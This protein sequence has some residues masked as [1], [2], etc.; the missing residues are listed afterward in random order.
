MES[1]NASIARGHWFFLFNAVRDLPRA[2]I[3]GRA[4]IWLRFIFESRTY[5]SAYG[6]RELSRTTVP[7]PR[8]WPRIKPTRR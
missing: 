7:A 6:Q 8:T 1:I 2:P 3:T 5:D 4:E